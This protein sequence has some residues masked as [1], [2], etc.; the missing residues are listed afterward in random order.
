MGFEL[1]IAGVPPQVIAQAI[2]SVAGG[3][4]EHQ[5]AFLSQVNDS[6][7]GDFN[8]ELDASLLRDRRYQSALEDMGVNIGHG[9]TR[10]N[11]ENWLAEIAGLM[12]PREIVAPPIAWKH[13]AELDK[14]REELLNAGAKGTHASPLYAFGLQINIESASLEAEYLLSILRAFLLSYDWLLE[15]A[16]VDLSRR[17]SPYVHAFPE[18]YA[19]HVL[20]PE[21]QPGIREL[22]DDYLR[23]TPTRNRP[24]DLL[25]LFAHVDEARVMEAPVEHELIKPRPAFHYRL[26]NCLIDEPDW[27][28][29]VPWNDW[30]AVEKLAA[31]PQDLKRL[32]QSRLHDSSEAKQWLSSVIRKLRS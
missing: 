5:S 29:A 25:P 7:L 30:V 24:L 12:V 1:E 2:V 17:I 8:I 28:L 32:C 26:P 13:L 23:Y 4:A 22:I 10:D 11:L 9:E 15:R 16:Q 27:S 19:V 6:S 3:T 18:D 20:D 31:Q 21:Y 14:I